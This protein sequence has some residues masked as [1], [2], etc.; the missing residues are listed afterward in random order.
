MMSRQ[1]SPR[2]RPSG[3]P[4]LWASRALTKQDLHGARLS[5]RTII[6]ADTHPPLP[7]GEHIGHL[8]GLRS[9]NTA[10][11]MTIPVG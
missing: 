7:G 9:G 8:P 3:A 10:F 5:P 4:A 1:S 11:A 6:T 2:K